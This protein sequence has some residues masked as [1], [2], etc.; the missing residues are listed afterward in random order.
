MTWF[1]LLN[2]CWL[3]EDRLIL[4]IHLHLP[5]PQLLL[6]R[7]TLYTGTAPSSLWALALEW[8]SIRPALFSLRL[9]SPWVVMTPL[10][11]KLWVHRW[12][13]S[14]SHS[15]HVVRY[16][17]METAS[18]FV[19]NWRDLTPLLMYGFLIVLPCSMIWSEVGKFG[20]SGSH[21]QRI[22]HVIS[23]LRM[24][25]QI[26]PLFYQCMEIMEIVCVLLCTIL[27]LSLLVAFNSCL[28]ILLGFVL[29]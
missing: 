4:P 14:C 3:W 18:L 23:W 26:R 19:I 29:H 25:L 7:T 2:L 8:P 16:T 28:E 22:P 21:G 24:L 17:F 20:S 27:F 13:H 6:Y 12:L 10:E 11:L 15:F 1:R 5:L 9:A